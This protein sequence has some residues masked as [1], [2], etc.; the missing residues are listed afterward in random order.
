MDTRK[1]KDCLP[2]TNFQEPA[3]TN[4]HFPSLV[5]LLSSSK[6]QYQGPSIKSTRITDILFSAEKNKNGGN[7]CTQEAQR[8]RWGHGTQEPTVQAG[9]M[10]HR[11]QQSRQGHR[12]KELQGTRDGSRT[13]VG[14][15]M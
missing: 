1:L 2:H 8:P 11:S 6:F 10:G 12:L 5:F 14:E 13:S 15:E 4:Y 3:R 7:C 9:N